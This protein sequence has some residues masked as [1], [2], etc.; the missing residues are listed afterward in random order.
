MKL[1]SLSRTGLLIVAFGL[2]GLAQQN[3]YVKTI[4]NLLGVKKTI[5]SPV[6]PGRSPLPA[7]TLF[8]STQYKSFNS[9]VMP[10]SMP[11]R[12]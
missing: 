12:H 3:G 2:P 9:P 1:V 11:V 7:P 5:P 4:N 6:Q 8:P 10:T